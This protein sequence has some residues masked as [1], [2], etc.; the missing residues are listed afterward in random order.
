MRSTPLLWRRQVARFWHERAAVVGLADCLALVG[1]TLTPGEFFRGCIGLAEPVFFADLDRA[2]VSLI[3]A[4]ALPDLAPGSLTRQLVARAC[5]ARDCSST[6]NGP[7]TAG[8]QQLRALPS[9]KR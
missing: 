7:K 3:V 2:L 1:A 4:E 5:K 6:T 9:R 8:Q